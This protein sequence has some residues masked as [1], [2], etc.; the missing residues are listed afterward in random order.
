LEFRY[1]IFTDSPAKPKL[2]RIA[3]FS[4]GFRLK[5]FIREKE[6]KIADF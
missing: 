6:V 3:S 4:D 2:F 5:I 1:A